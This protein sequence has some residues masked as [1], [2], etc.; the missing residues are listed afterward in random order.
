MKTAAGNQNFA[1]SSF[2]VAVDSKYTRSKAFSEIV[3]TELHLE[4]DILWSVARIKSRMR[5][6]AAESQN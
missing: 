4:F 3:S 6:K 1:P 5:H 2:R